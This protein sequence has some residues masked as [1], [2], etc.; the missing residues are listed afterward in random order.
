MLS[1]PMD[2]A[3]RGWGAYTEG[4]NAHQRT[5]APAGIPRGRWIVV[6]GFAK[7]SCDARWWAAGSVT[8]LAQRLF[9]V[10]RVGPHISGSRSHSG[11]SAGRVGIDI[12]EFLTQVIYD[13]TLGVKRPD[14]SG[15]PFAL[16]YCN[17]PDDFLHQGDLARNE[18]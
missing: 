17:R 11:P 10:A 3:G 15:D 7:R 9:A 16:L 12:L 1:S 14:L 5:H 18:R 8:A 2:G 6:F 13:L 4:A